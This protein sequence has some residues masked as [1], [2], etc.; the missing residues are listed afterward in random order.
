MVWYADMYVLTA[1][2]SLSVYRCWTKTTK[3]Q[4]KASNRA[5]CDWFR[6]ACSTDTSFRGEHTHVHMGHDAVF[7]KQVKYVAV[8]L[9][10]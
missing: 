5:E 1:L 10:L 8:Q 7:S 6:S 3:P 9:S 2:L 4:P